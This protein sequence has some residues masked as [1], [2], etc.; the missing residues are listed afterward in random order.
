MPLPR[1]LAIATDPTPHRWG[2]L[3]D[4]LHVLTQELEAC[5]ARALE[6][7]RLHHLKETAR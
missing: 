1:A 5:E 4:A 2:D 6:T 7:A 3:A